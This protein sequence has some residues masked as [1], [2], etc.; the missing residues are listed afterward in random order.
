M[1]IKGIVKIIFPETSGQSK[2][3][4]W[5]KQEILITQNEDKF[6]S[7]V[8]VTYFSNK[9]ASG[10]APGQ[11]VKVQVSASSKEYNGRWYTVL[12]AYST[13]KIGEAPRQESRSSSIEQMGSDALNNSGPDELPF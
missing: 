5:T 1:E 4:T 8:I 11:A 2:K 3:G 10:L 12:K 9:D 13:E 6:P 7:D